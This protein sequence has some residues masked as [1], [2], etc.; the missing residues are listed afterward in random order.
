MVSKTLFVLLSVF[1]RVLW[2]VGVTCLCAFQLLT[3]RGAILED[4][5]PSTSKHGTVRGLPLK[6][7]LEYVIPELSTPCLRLALSTPKVTEQLLKLDEQGVWDMKHVAIESV[8]RKGSYCG[9]FLPLVVVSSSNRLFLRFQS[10]IQGCGGTFHEEVDMINSKNWPESLCL[11]TV[12][13]PARKTI[14]VNFP[15]FE[16]EEP[17][18]FTKKCFDSLLIYDKAAGIAEKYGPYC[19]T[20]LPPAITSKGN[21]LVMRFNAD[22]FTEAQGF[23]AYWTTDPT[24]PPPTEGSTAVTQ[25]LQIWLSRPNSWQ[26]CLGKHNMTF[27]APTERCSGVDAIIIHEDF[28][29]PEG[30][31]ISNDIALIH[32]KQKNQHAPRNQPFMP[33]KLYRYTALRNDKGDDKSSALPVVAKKLNQAPLLIVPYET[34]SKPMYCWNQVRPSMVCAGIETPDELKS[35]CQVTVIDVDWDRLPF[36]VKQLKKQLLGFVWIAVL[37]SLINKTIVT[38][39]SSCSF[40]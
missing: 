14:T 5:V 12:E 6:D 10:E 38:N 24:V 26:M 35:A 32:L 21:K 11:W 2:D 22:F 4:A 19:G 37:Q 30:N 39:P 9:L 28:R 13:V 20:K 1:L 16:V 17:A 7:V 15:H 34:C 27:F 3:L 25:H 29:Y 18:P 33:T 31:G 40:S 8:Y 36:Q 23:R